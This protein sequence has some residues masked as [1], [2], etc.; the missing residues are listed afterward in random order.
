MG[1]Y[2]TIK[3]GQVYSRTVGERDKMG[4]IKNTNDVKFPEEMNLSGIA[5]ITSRAYFSQKWFP[6]PLS[7]LAKQ[8]KKW[9]IYGK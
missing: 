1:R 7:A 3:C 6:E 5:K 4:F 2:K 8:Y 9:N